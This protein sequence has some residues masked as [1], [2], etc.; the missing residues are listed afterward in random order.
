LKA[1]L[2]KHRSAASMSREAIISGGWQQPREAKRPSGSLVA[3][4]AAGGNQ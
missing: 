4:A 2:A 3:A 1:A